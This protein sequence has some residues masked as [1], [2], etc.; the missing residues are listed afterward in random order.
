MLNFVVFFCSCFVFI[1]AMVCVCSIALLVLDLKYERYFKP[2]MF[3]IVLVVI[4]ACFYSM[5]C[6][7]MCFNVLSG[8][9]VK[10][11]DCV[12]L[13]SDS[14]I[15][16]YGDALSNGFF[17]EG[18]PRYFEYFVDDASFSDCV[19]GDRVD[20]LCRYYRFDKPFDVWDFVGV[21]P[22]SYFGHADSLGVHKVGRLEGESLDAF[23]DLVKSDV[24]LRNATC[25]SDSY[26]FM[27]EG[28]LVKMKDVGYGFMI[29]DDLRSMVYLPNVPVDISKPCRVSFASVEWPIAYTMVESKSNRWY[30][31]WQ[32]IYRRE[33]Q[34]FEII[35]YLSDD[36]ISDMMHAF[37]SDD[38]LSRFM[39]K[40]AW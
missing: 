39:D 6:H 32:S 2:F 26:L 28:I 7:D 8:I 34:D 4:S 22:L 5:F 29:D 9:V 40:I 3:S 30:D 1:F 18:Q 20:V 37:E 31:D 10:F 15:V 21:S 25:L 19:T 23:L 27:H 17:E 12:I 14:N 16:T 11:D 36:D 13:Y 33:I 38:V 24:K 35:E